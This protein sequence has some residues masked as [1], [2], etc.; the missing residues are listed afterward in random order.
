M[1]R[2]CLVAFMC[3]FIPTQVLSADYIIGDGD[4]LVVSVW[5]APEL[6]TTIVVRPDGKI[7]LPAVG[8]VS[9]SGLT[10]A[11]LSHDLNK[12]LGSYVKTPIV[13]V[14]V[15]T[16]TNNRIY[17]SGGG[18]PSKVTNL[19]ARTTLFKLLCSLEGIQNVDMKRAYLVRNG[20]AQFNDFYD[21]FVNSNIDKDFEL[22][23]ED[24]LYLPSN[25]Q[26][27]VYV[28]GAVIEPKALIYREG[29]RV[30]DAVFEC[31]GFSK[32]AKQSAVLIIRK[33]NGKDET[34]KIDI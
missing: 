30:L 24:I 7:T 22:Q 21:L 29:L 23:P 25:E 34:I 13:T 26:N 10:P 18:I 19:S 6:S 15:S 16:I 8:D 33:D 31:G 3:V 11:Q 9:A 5:G 27:K 17:I 14:A 12:V 4:T 1:I 32:Y 2:F 28:V 20:K